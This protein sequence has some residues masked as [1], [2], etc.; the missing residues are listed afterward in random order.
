MKDQRAP[1]GGRTA[2][3]GKRPQRERTNDLQFKTKYLRQPKKRMLTV[4]TTTGTKEQG[5]P[6]HLTNLDRVNRHMVV[7]I[8]LNAEQALQ[9]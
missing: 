8:M 5:C 2:E 7:P 6:P 3:S 1:I 4:R 9:V